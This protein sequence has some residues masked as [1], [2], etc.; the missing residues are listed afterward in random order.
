[1]IQNKTEYKKCEIQ[2]IGDMNINLL[3]YSS[4]DLT[5][6][7]LE[8]LLS[9]GHLPLITQPTRIQGNSATLID[10]ITTTLQTERYDSGVIIDSISDHFPVFFVQHKKIKRPPPIEV[11]TRKINN[12]TIPPFLDLLKS[13]DWHPIVNNNNPESA[14]RSFFDTIDAAVD[15]SFPEVTIKTKPKNISFSPWMTPGL[16]KSSKTKQCLFTK[17]L[18]YPTVGNKKQFISYNGVFNKVRRA[19]K[20]DYYS[21][22]FAENKNNIKRTWD[23]IREVIGKRKHREN[24][25]DF[26]KHNGTILTEAKDI[27]EGFNGFFAG[28]GPELASKFTVNNNKFR[29]YLGNA[30]DENFIF[31]TLTYDMIN[32][33]AG[34]LKPK[35]SAGADSISSKLLKRMLPYIISPVCHL[36]N[37][38]LKSGYIPLQLKTAKV[39][40]VY[41]SEEKC[42]FT[43][44][45]PISL[46]SSFS[47]LLEKIVARQVIGFLYK[48]QIL[49][50]HQYGF[51]RGH[52]TTHPIIQF[53]DKIYHGFNANITSFT[54]GIFLDL[55]KAF[56]TVDFP[57]LIEKLKHYGIRGMSNL[58]FTNYRNGR[59]QYVVIDGV[60]SS[61][62][63]IKCGVP[64]G[65]VL[66]PLLFLIFINDLPA[67]TDFHTILFADDTTFQLTGSNI[68][69]L[70]NKANSELAKAADWFAANKLT[71]NIKKTK[72]ILFRP[73][74]TKIDFSNLTLKIGNQPIDRIGKGCKAT[75][76]KFVGIMLDEFLDWDNH[77]SHVSAKVS[78]GSFTLNRSKYFIPIKTRKNIYNALIRSHLDFGVL[79]WG[80]ALPGKLKRITCIQ[81]KCVR[82]VAGRDIRSHTDPLYKKLGILKFNDLI[83]YNQ[84]TFM[85]KLYLDKQPSSF[86]DFLKKPGN[87]NNNENRRK[88]CYSTDKLKNYTVGR[89]PTAVLPRLWNSVDT[90]TKSIK[91]HKS[92]KKSIY[93]SILNKYTATVKCKS[94]TCPDCLPQ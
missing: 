75:S 21:N 59:Q 78:S 31:T 68:P 13:K 72:Y 32:E 56:D 6:Q 8:F 89:F 19:A 25:P 93:E 3:N 27:A 45:R 58:W 50:K 17:K 9:N 23:V 11:Q 5:Q 24:L 92:F 41:K 28:I 20:K 43:N 69:E 80:N 94:R 86:T 47:K 30:I 60:N 91:S 48:K 55:K 4:H 37:L 15:M 77:I 38:S 62:T 49:Y 33:V 70:Y 54:L 79:A 53:L 40:P 36:F 16:L 76:F 44:Y 14:F 66:G 52:S 67:A 82:S 42:H 90:E 35:N 22:Q 73:K 46:L 85:H 51:R 2:F 34:K 81:K 1:M 87:F 12:T 61:L 29:T 63:S 74:S 10:H 26:F 57:I 84:V 7:Y 83:Y 18:K 64:Q 71:L 39:I 88:F 65:S